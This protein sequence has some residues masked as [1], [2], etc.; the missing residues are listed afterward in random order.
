M[1]VPFNGG[2]ITRQTGA[3]APPFVQIEMSR[4]LYLSKPHFDDRTLEIDDR[5]VKDLNAKVWKVLEK[6]VRNI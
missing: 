2:Y 3:G 5:R 4:V 1:N 6:T